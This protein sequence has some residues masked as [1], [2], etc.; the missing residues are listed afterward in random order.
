MAAET[1]WTKRIVESC[2]AGSWGRGCQGSV[3]HLNDMQCVVFYCLHLSAWSPV[4]MFMC[5]LFQESNQP[6]NFIIIFFFL[7]EV[8]NLRF[9]LW[10][11]AKTRIDKS[12]DTEKVQRWESEVYYWRLLWRQFPYYCSLVTFTPATK[13]FAHRSFP[14]VCWHSPANV[15]WRIAPAARSAGSACLISTP[16]VVAV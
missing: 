3:T 11:I 1:S 15:T 4:A 13:W 7:S 9:C 10:R 12:R 16:N 8:W 14:N 5:F 2:P 6:F